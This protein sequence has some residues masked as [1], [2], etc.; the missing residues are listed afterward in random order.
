MYIP[1]SFY[2]RDQK[3]AFH[4]M[5]SHSFATL[6]SGNNA[7][8][9]ASHLPF[10]VE[11]VGE[12]ILLT[13]HL[14][15]NNP[16]LKEYAANEVLIIFNGPHAYVSPI[17]YESKLSVPTWNYIAV[18]AYGKIKFLTETNQVIAALEK[19]ISFYDHS[20]QIQWDELP[21]DYKTRMLNGISAFETDITSVQMQKKMSQNK[22]ENEKNKIVKSLENSMNGHER[23]LAVYMNNL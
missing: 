8:F 6:V 18:H 1:E 10:V 23:E 22:T 3:E 14:A 16:Q 7:N 15:K 21:L 5:Q 11:M 19:T 4:F 12:Q 9:T 17:H 20:Y 13:S 2:E